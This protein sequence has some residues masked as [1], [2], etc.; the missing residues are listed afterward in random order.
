ML[1]TFG[2]IFFPR[3]IHEEKKLRTRM[4][5]VAVGGG[6]IVVVG[7]SGLMLYLYS[8]SHSPALTKP[9]KTQSASPGH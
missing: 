4:K 5:L 3:M 6:L 2:R 1:Y 8:R 9:L 7:V